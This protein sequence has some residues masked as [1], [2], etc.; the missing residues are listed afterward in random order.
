MR[1]EEKLRRIRMKQTTY[2][3]SNEELKIVQEIR[4]SDVYSI[5]HIPMKSSGAAATA[6][7]AAAAVAAVHAEW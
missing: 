3:T 4:G 2:R 6:A 1:K 7:A 5:F